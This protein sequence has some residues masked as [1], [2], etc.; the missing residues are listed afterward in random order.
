MGNYNYNPLA[1]ST[2]NECP[3][4]VGVMVSVTKNF[5]AVNYFSSSD[6]S[7]LLSRS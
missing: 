4:P 7:H 6:L 5:S 2:R 1:V 3:S